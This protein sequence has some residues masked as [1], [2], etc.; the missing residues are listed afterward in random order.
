MLSMHSMHC[1]VLREQER[2]RMIISLAG[3]IKFLIM[4]KYA[5]SRVTVSLLLVGQTEKPEFVYTECMFCLA[6]RWFESSAF[7]SDSFNSES[8]DGQQLS[9]SSVRASYRIIMES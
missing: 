3:N 9:F 7:L 2:S 6:W 5:H 8:A 4:W 1:V